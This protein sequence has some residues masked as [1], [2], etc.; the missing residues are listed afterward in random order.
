MIETL[1][2]LVVGNIRSRRTISYD[3]IRWLECRRLD[4]ESWY[5]EGNFVCLL[6]DSKHGQLLE[7]DEFNMQVL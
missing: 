2:K 6:H 3:N 1:G 4:L 5:L 7:L